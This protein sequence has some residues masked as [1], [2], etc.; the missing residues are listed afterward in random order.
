M[1]LDLPPVIDPGT[2]LVSGSMAAKGRSAELISQEVPNLHL[3][4]VS[5]HAPPAGS[6]RPEVEAGF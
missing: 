6:K 3:K 2:E 5:G 4:T 1:K